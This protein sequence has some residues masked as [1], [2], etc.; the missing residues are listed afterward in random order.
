MRCQPMAVHIAHGIAPAVREHRGQRLG[1]GIKRDPDCETEIDT[2]EFRLTY[3]G[4]LL[5]ASGN[6]KR[7][8]H[9]HE[10]RKVFHK[11]LRRIFEIHPAYEYYHLP[12]DGPEAEILTVKKRFDNTAVR[13]SPDRLPVTA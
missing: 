5:G 2:M 8:K 6:N 4:L 3:E 1:E 10:I 11:Q 7:A 9:K 13:L 12:K